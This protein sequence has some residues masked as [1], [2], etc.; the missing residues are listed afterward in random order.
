MVDV[1]ASL[2]S[3]HAVPSIRRGS[4]VITGSERDTLTIRFYS[5][6]CSLSQKDL[7]IAID[8]ETGRKDLRLG[9]RCCTSNRGLTLIVGD[10]NR[11]EVVGHCREQS[12][13]AC[14]RN[15]EVGSA[16]V[17]ARVREA[18]KRIFTDKSIVT[19]QGN[20]DMCHQ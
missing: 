6:P 20:Y 1:R 10:I 16:D 7:G 15:G 3:S 4:S 11:P 2:Q 13:V 14:V 18:E 17:R 8:K 12:F 5:N 9:G 19:H